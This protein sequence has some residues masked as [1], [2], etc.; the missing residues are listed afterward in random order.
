LLCRGRLHDGHGWLA[1][2]DRG[3]SQGS[4]RPEHLAG[5]RGFSSGNSSSRRWRQ[6]AAWLDGWTHKDVFV[7][8]VLHHS[9]SRNRNSSGMDTSGRAL[10]TTRA[11]KGVVVHFRSVTVFRKF[12]NFLEPKKKKLVAAQS[13]Q[14]T[15]EHSAQAKTCFMSALFLSLVRSEAMDSKRSAKN[16]NTKDTCRLHLTHALGCF[17]LPLFSFSVLPVGRPV[18]GVGFHAFL[19]CPVWRFFFFQPAT[20]GKTHLKRTVYFWLCLLCLLLSTIQTN[21]RHPPLVDSQ[22]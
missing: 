7:N 19:L 10:Q 14:Q 4:R 20:K 5:Q 9:S 16:E 18:I 22:P 12:R 17:H 11:A 15:A 3:S 8:V 6:Q 13:A 21:P 2:D 1:V